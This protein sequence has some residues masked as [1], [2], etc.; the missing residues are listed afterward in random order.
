MAV[1]QGIG[2]EPALEIVSDAREQEA[3]RVRRGATLG[4]VLE[5]IAVSI[6]ATVRLSAVA[7]EAGV[8]TVPEY[9]GRGYAR[10][11]VSAWAQEVRAAGIIPLYSRWSASAW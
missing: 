5:G 4:V 8:D 7:A 1:E 6:C 11:V 2:P 9:R 10:R 3:L